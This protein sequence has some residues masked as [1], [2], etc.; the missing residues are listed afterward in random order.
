M[1]WDLDGGTS[2]ALSFTISYKAPPCSDDDGDM[3]AMDDFD[4][5]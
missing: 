4:D 2:L 1:S 5:F 3:I